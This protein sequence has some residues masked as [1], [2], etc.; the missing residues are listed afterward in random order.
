MMLDG[1]LL[2]MVMLSDFLIAS[3]VMLE[4][5]LDGYSKDVEC[6]RS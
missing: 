2:V 5:F 4:W 6:S 3:K 1:L